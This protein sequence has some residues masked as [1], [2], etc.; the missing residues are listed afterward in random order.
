MAGGSL[1]PQYYKE[2]MNLAVLLAPPATLYYNNI[3]GATLL[4]KKSV[5]ELL[6]EGGKLVHLY[7]IL[8]WRWTH[9]P[10]E[11]FC[12]L[13]DGK[14]CDVMLHFLMNLDPST[15]NH[16]RYGAAFSNLPSGASWKSFLHYFQLG[17][18]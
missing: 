14:L 8:S 17:P 16:S 7:N 6:I 1:L 10:C 11:F 2:K 12:T 3:T 13:F 9:K 4:A 18:G 15:D 5:Q